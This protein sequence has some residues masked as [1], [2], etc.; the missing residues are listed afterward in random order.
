[1][2]F[3]Q[4][5]KPPMQDTLPTVLNRTHVRGWNEAIA[6]A[7]NMLA[8]QINCMKAHTNEDGLCTGEDFFA[9][10]LAYLEPVLAEIRRL[11]IDLPDDIQ[12]KP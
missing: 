4:S 6:T 1:M 8:N 5:G 2:T 7:A 3:I 11:H 10:E 9:T 12:G